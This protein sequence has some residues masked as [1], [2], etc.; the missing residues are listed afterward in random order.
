MAPVRLVILGRQGSGKGTQCERL[1][2]AFGCVHLSTGEMLRAAVAEG[3]ELGREAESIMDA[4]GLV[5]DEIINA[6]VRER[7][8]GDDITASGVLFDGYP[9]TSEQADALEAILGERGQR[10]DAAVNIE[11]PTAEAIARMLQR[12]RSDDTADAI[13]RRL[14]LY[15][16]QT[17]PLLDWF[18]RRD[19]LVTVDGVGTADEVFT[20]VSAAVTGDTSHAGAVLDV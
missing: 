7:L 4:G 14:D 20:R 17:A 13:E 16:R 3:T 11:V 8:R 9:R 19:L 6:I 2:E 15:E 18:E 10:L 5:G 1:V 12:G